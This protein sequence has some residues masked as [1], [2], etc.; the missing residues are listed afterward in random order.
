MARKAKVIDPTKPA[1]ISATTEEDFSKDTGDYSP[2]KLVELATFAGIFVYDLETVGFNPRLGKI[3]GVAVYIPPF[4]LPTGEDHPEV[5]AWFPFTENTMVYVRGKDVISLRPAMDP[6]DTM[7]RLRALWSLPVRKVAANGK[8]DMGWL[9]LQSGTDEAIR[10]VDQICDSMLADYMTD[11][12]RYKY[13]LK[14]RVEEVFNVKM[15]TYE[16]ASQRQGQFSFMNP[17]PLGIY[18]M[19]DAKWTYK[20]HEHAL[21]LLKAQD[22]QDPK[23]CKLEKIYWNI[24]MKLCRIL[25]EM[26]TRGCLL[27]W[28]HLQDLERRLEAEKE[29]IVKDIINKAGWAPNLRSPKQVSDFLFNPVEEGGLGL[30]TDGLEQGVDGDYCVIKGTRVETQHGMLKIEDVK[31]GDQVRL[32]NK[33]FA[34]VDR[35]IDKGL[36]PVT[37]ISTRSGYV[38]TATDLHKIRVIDGVGNYVWKEVRDIQLGDRVAIQSDFCRKDIN[39]PELLS[40]PMPGNYH[41]KDLITPRNLTPDVAKFIGYLVGDGSFQEKEISWVVSEKDN[42]V[43][44]WS[45]AAAQKLFGAVPSY[46]HY[47]G[48]FEGRISRRLLSDWFSSEQISKEYIFPKLWTA[49]EDVVCSFL[50]GLFEADGSVNRTSKRSDITWSSSREKLAK[51][52]QLLLL[53]VGI[54]SKLRRVVSQNNFIGWHLRIYSN[55][56]NVFLEKIGFIGQAK[57]SRLKIYCESSVTAD[58]VGGFPNLSEKILSLDIKDPVEKKFVSNTV[59]FG[60]DITKTTALKLKLHN[61]KTY[62]SLELNRIVEYGQIFDTVSSKENIGTDH[63]YDL[64]VPGPMTYISDGFVSHN[65]TSEKVIKHF[66]R[67]NDLVQKLLDYRSLEVIDRSF[68]KKLIKI[69]LEDDGRVHAGFNQ[70]GTVTGRLSCV[71]AGTYVEIARGSLEN[72]ISIKIEDVK[73]GDL[74]YTYDYNLNLTI[75]KVNNVWKTGHRKVIRLHWRGTGQHTSGHLDLTPEHPVRLVTNCYIKAEQL[76]PDDT[77]MALGKDIYSD[78]NHA[79]TKVEVLEDSV[80]VYDLEIEG[81]HNF[82]AN[83]ICVHNSSKPVNLM[84]QPREKNMIRK[85][86]VARLPQDSSSDLVLLDGDYGQIELRLASHFACE[87]NMLDVYNSGTACPLGCERYIAGYECKVK[88]C[89][90]EGLIKNGDKKCGKCGSPNVSWQERCRHIDLHQRTSEDVG[91]VR[92]PLAKNLNFGLLYRMGGPKFVIYANLYDEDGLPQTQ[93]ANELVAKWHEAYPGIVPWHYIVEDKLRR[94]NWIA[95]TIAGRRRRLDQE[96][97]F[98]EYRAITQA[99]NFVIQGSAQDIIKLGMI[100]VYEER[101]ARIAKAAPAERKIWERFKFIIQ[102]HDEVVWEVPLSIADEVRVMIKHK[103]ENVAKLRVPLVFSIKQG[104]NW[105]DAH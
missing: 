72:P 74:A 50:Q 58:R 20:L 19:D 85:A 41:K 103:M 31:K 65:S 7:T 15:T 68:C 16:E 34:I 55:Y 28:N 69:A 98:N 39:Y 52:V 48:V 6:Y 101:E 61:P 62:N 79:I 18:A 82:I 1:L 43:W 21:A 73:P 24:E 32:D 86:F 42:D 90:W 49:S 81:T 26:E 35:T 27:D 5:R 3:E 67:K 66:G 78:N 30:P 75:A 8:Y 71:A 99:I 23:R 104:N 9:L 76:I 93:Y 88:T 17:K 46:R 37:K 91:V 38:L 12:R 77:V 94:D 44:M 70:T 22:A 45:L 83:E 47:R 29:S 33:K 100:Q 63:V 36:L 64:S 4:K 87:K 80:D 95:Y 89:K 51:D 92:N 14:N 59:S 57:M 102:V 13:G 56:I 2:E 96:K 53:R 40:T 11:E 105:E 60:R 25:V 54:I 10:V 97:A 84:N